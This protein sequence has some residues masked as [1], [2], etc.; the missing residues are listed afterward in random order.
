MNGIRQMS[1]VTLRISWMVMFMDRAET[2]DG[3][4]GEEQ[5]KDGEER[6]VVEELKRCQGIWMEKEWMKRRTRI[7]DSLWGR[8][9]GLVYWRIEIR[10]PGGAEIFIFRKESYQPWDLHSHLFNE[11][12]GHFPWVIKVVMYLHLM[13]EIYTATSSRRAECTV[14]GA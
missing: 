12:R 11:G 9:Y 14:P 2:E 1:P 10:F 8:G 3:G 5:R 4:C 7:P 6:R 13:S